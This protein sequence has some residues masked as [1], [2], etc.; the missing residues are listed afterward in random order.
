MKTQIA[1]HHLTKYK[2]D[3]LVQLGP[4]IVRLR[5]APHARTH[6]N[7]YSLKINVEKHFLHWQQDPFGNYLARI[8][9]PDKIKEFQVEVDLVAEIQAFNP[10]DFFHEEYAEKL[11][12]KYE[13]SLAEELSPYL[14]IKDK[15]K[16]LMECMSS[17]ECVP[18]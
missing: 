15:G 6:I 9:I 12:F 13:K 5:P 11:P 3:R 17:K 18:K 1:L 7:S 14:E 16:L 2:Y 4:Q 8:L 10:F